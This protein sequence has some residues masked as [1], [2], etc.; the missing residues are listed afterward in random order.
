M[1]TVI[2][3][4]CPAAG[5]LASIAW[6]AGGMA[7]S[8]MQLVPRDT[9]VEALAR[10]AAITAAPSGPAA[11]SVSSRRPTTARAGKPQGRRRF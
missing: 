4:L 9:A 8:A 2:I 7:A 10:P 6:L 11:R 3:S 5:W 1:M